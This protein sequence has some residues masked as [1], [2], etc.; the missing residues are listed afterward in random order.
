MHDYNLTK[1]EHEVL[2][3]TAHEFTAREIAHKLF[4]STHTVIS[5]RKNLYQKLGAKNPAGM[6]RAAFEMGILNTAL[7]QNQIN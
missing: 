5:H 4:I 6:I 1:R 2:H 7:N 3:L